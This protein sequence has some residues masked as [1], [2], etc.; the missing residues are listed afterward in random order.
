MC[1]ELLQFRWKVQ[2]ILESEFQM[3]TTYQN[4]KP[5]ITGDNCP[6]LLGNL[7][8]AGTLHWITVVPILTCRTLQVRH[9]SLEHGS[10]VCDAKL[11]RN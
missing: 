11:L 1:E 4:S 2:A 3:Y 7:H 8:N 5:E 9:S 10:K 6:K